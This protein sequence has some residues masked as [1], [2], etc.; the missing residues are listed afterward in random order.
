MIR[1]RAGLWILVILS[2]LIALSSY[3]FIGLGFPLAF[4]DFGDHLDARWW[5]FVSHVGAAPVALLFGALQFVETVR[6]KWPALHRWLGRIYVAAVMLGGVSGL[7]LAVNAVG[8]PVA[9]LGFG[10]LSV[11]W[12]AFTLQ[13]F[14]MA[15]G[16]RFVEHRRWMIRSF[17]LTFAAVTLRLYLAGFFA[18]GIEYAPASIVLGWISWVPNLLVAQWWLT[19][20]PNPP[21]KFAQSL[22]S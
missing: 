17:A 11:L 20:F 1:G 4:P 8:G 9:S 2:S 15:R 7:G 3:R 21:G 10:L 12:M 22:A 19:R 13:G 6:S 18:A 16:R 5:T 14:R